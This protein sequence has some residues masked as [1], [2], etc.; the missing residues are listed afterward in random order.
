MSITTFLDPPHPSIFQNVQLIN[1]SVLLADTHTTLCWMLRCDPP[2]TQNTVSVGNTSILTAPKVA[3]DNLFND[4]S[5][6]VDDGKRRRTGRI[7]KIPQKKRL[8][9]AKLRARLAERSSMDGVVKPSKSLPKKSAQSM[10]F[11]FPST[12]WPYCCSRNH[13]IN[14]GD[15][16]IFAPWSPRLLT[17]FCFVFLSLIDNCTLQ[18]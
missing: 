18:I 6:G 7:R 1:S 11:P 10:T 8:R 5:M 17:C 15:F 12:D 13:R 2:I 4:H 16:F 9:L 14:C 3:M